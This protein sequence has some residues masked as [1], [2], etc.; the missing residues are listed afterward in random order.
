MYYLY[1]AVLILAVILIGRIAYI[2]L[3]GK[4]DKSVERY[5]RP[6]SDK[7]VIDPERGAII[8]S[9]GKLLAMSTPLYE[10]FMDCTVR[11]DY[12]E[13]KGRE[14]K[15]LEEEWQDKAKLFA[16]GL[17]AEMGGDSDNYWKMIQKGRKEGNK[18]LR[19]GHPVD[20]ETLLRLKKLPLMEEGQYKS[21][22][23]VRKKDSRQYPYGKLAMR[24][25]GYV[26]D[27]SASNGNNHI[28][29]EG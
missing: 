20:R 5:F 4:L 25:I 2:Q 15:K 24:T 7:S 8:G 14:G 3:F 1:T 11:K 28:G 21:G 9:D 22:V 6:A 29:L 16:K 18:F 10:L 17:A 23:I 27:N 12:F 13:T 26:K 19:L